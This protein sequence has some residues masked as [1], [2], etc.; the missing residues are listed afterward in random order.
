ME[1]PLVLLHGFPFDARL[2]QEVVALLPEYAER[3]LTPNLPGFGGTPP[4]A[5]F[6]LDAQAEWLYRYLTEHGAET[7]VLAGHSMGGYLALAF[8]ARYP[9]KVAGLGLIHSTSAPDTPEK[10]QSRNEQIAHLQQ[11]GTRK[12]VPKLI[13]PLIAPA[14]TEALAVPLQ[15]F[16]ER[17]MALPAATLAG[18]IAALRDRPDRAAVLRGATFP[19]VILAGTYDPVVSPAAARS[20]AALVPGGAQLVEAHESGHLA[21]LEEPRVVADALRSLLQLA[22]SARTA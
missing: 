19:V 6:S 20:Q 17:A 15:S 13:E 21:M 3:I 22:T 1:S 2:W 14:H 11:H 16:I 7:A 18:T 9:E 12:L 8:V 4:P 10:K 5:D